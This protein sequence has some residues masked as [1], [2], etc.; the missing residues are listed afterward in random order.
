MAFATANVVREN[1]GSI[2]SIRGSWTGTVGD[3]VG[4]VTG[5]G[6]ASSAEFDANLSETPGEKLIPRITNSSG[7][8]TVTIPY[9]R[10]VTAG[11]FVIRFK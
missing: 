6:F 9:H 10:T 2:N 7:T 11:T 8:W 1:M 3:D 4:T 5:S